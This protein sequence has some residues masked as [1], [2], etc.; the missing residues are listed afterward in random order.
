MAAHEKLVARFKTQPA[1]FT[2]DELVRP[3]EGCGY[4]EA[5]RGASSRRTF[6]GPGR[7]KIKLHKP[8]PSNLV[9][10]YVLKEVRE[11]LEKAGL[12]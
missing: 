7:P 10:R 2:W 11:T 12:I 1:D 3:L 9:K 4:Q 8:H 6:D 5:K